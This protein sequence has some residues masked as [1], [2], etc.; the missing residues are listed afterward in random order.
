MV[1]KTPCNKVIIVKLLYEGLVDQWCLRLYSLRII[2]IPNFSEIMQVQ[3]SQTGFT[4]HFFPYYLH[5]AMDLY[6]I[7]IL[8]Q[9]D[10]MINLVGKL[11]TRLSPEVVW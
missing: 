3:E 6:I 11:S 9:M 10:S 5:K 2:A 7:H 4:L 8:F 1:T